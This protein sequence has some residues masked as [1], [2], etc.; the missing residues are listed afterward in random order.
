MNVTV[1][2]AV[3]LVTQ[4]GI[5]NGQPGSHTI[6]LDG[7]DAMYVVFESTDIMFGPLAFPKIISD[8]TIDGQGRMITRAADVE[9]FRF[10]GVDSKSPDTYGKLT[11]L[12]LKLFNGESDA[13]GGAIVNDGELHIE[14][15]YFSGNVS[16]G[17][18]AIYGGDLRPLVIS[19]SIFLNNTAIGDNAKG[20]AIYASTS[21]SMNIS[22]CTFLYNRVKGDGSRG[23]A[24][25]NTSG[26]SAAM[27]DSN[28]FCNDVIDVIDATYNEAVYSVSNFTVED[29][30]WGDASGP[31]G[32]GISGSGQP[33][34][35]N[36]TVTNFSSS[37]ISPTITILYDRSGVAEYA[38][39]QSRINFEY[40]PYGASN[41]TDHA[42]ARPVDPLDIAQGSV[43]GPFYYASLVNHLSGHGG[44]GSAVFIS[45]SLHL[46]GGLPMILRSVEDNDCAVSPPEGYDWQD[47][48]WRMCCNENLESNSATGTWRNHLGIVGFFGTLIATLEANDLSGLMNF[49]AGTFLDQGA[50]ETF[51]YNLFTPGE[52]LGDVKTGDYIF[53][54]NETHGF[55]IVGWGPAGEC[56]NSLNAQTTDN[57][58][59]TQFSVQRILDENGNPT[60]QVPYIVDF[61]YGFTG[62][63]NPLEPHAQDNQTGWLQDPRPRPFYCSAAQM[64]EAILD[65][66]TNDDNANLDY[67]GFYISDYMQRVRSLLERFTINNVLPDWLFYHFP[68]E[69]TLDFSE[70]H[71]PLNPCRPIP[72]S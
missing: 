56:P 33:I 49:G 67:Y 16:A 6:T 37:P 9:K 63:G 68:D 2:N 45:E 46:G 61:C 24:I 11:L 40:F 32:G 4:I 7:N 64:N 18:G 26:V 42:V 47:I 43:G 17:G 27:S 65:R 12:G 31:D 55:L 1:S 71:C 72:E 66:D 34:G 39:E 23:S 28:I 44:T 58:P 21:S 8:I 36:I 38:I 20:G 69:M 3:D 54:S 59:N 30:W 53:L 52:T 19:D 48:G 51:I 50:F 60:N 57:S 62:L 22:N 70:L 15:C 29:N 14:D 10:F 25:Y 5:L 41:V 13:G 35:G